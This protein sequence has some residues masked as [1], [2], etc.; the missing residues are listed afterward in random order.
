MISRPSDLINGVSS[1]HM[2]VFVLATLAAVSSYLL[3]PYLIKEHEK[4]LERAHEL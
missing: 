2:A 4:A 3:V 1:E